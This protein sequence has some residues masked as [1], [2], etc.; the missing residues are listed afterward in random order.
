[1]SAKEKARNVVGGAFADRL[2]GERPGAMRAAAGAA[3]AGGLTTVVVYRLLRK[4]GDS[5]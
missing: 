4:G 1:V 5:D 2:G 3:M